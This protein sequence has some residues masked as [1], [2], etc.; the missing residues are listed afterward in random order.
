VLGLQRAFHAAGARS[1]MASLWSVSDPATALLMEEFYTNLWT[2]K[3]SKLEALRQAQLTVLNHPER[4]QKKREELLAALK[5]QGVGEDVLRGVKGRFATELPDGGVVGPA[6]EKPR[7]P[8]A[9]WAAFVLSGDPG[10]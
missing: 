5:Q 4:V 8:V 10:K 6:K 1:V 3:L 9:W 7:S 2:K